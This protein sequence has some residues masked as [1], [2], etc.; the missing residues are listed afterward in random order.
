MDSEAE[1]LCR[2]CHGCQVVSVYAPPEHMARAF[3]PC[4]PWEDCAA[5]ILGPLPKG[6]SLLVVVDYFSRYLRWL[7]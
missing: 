2:S 6:E 7:F 4:G 3:M 5:D 1:K